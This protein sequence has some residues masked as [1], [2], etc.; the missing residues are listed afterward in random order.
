MNIIF[1][2]ISILKT[3]SISNYKFESNSFLI[4][5]EDGLGASVEIIVPSAEISKNLGML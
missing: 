2:L 1:Y 3:I 4:S 5:A